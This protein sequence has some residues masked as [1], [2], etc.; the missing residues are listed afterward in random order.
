[1]ARKSVGA[2]HVTDKIVV[3]TPHG[4]MSGSGVRPTAMISS[5]DT[6]PGFKPYSVHYYFISSIVGVIQ[7]LVKICVVR[8][9]PILFGK[10]FTM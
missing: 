1:M 3:K 6:C 5:R 9:I 2:Q 10:G 8:S 4:G 7:C